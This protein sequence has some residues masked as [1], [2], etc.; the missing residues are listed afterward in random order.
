MNLTRG[1]PKT[2]L[3]LARNILEEIV[4]KDAKTAE[5]IIV[6]HVRD[7]LAQKFGVA[8][9]VYQHKLQQ[10]CL[11]ELWARVIATKPYDKKAA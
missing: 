7:Y 10:K 11:T 5:L 1:T 9:L 3:E 8:N 6:A 4:G 2:L